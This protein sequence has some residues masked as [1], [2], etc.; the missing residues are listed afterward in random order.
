LQLGDVS[1][2]SKEAY[3]ASVRRWISE[4]VIIKSLADIVSHDNQTL[5]LFHD[6]D[7]TAGWSD[8]NWGL[9]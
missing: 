4:G 7:P 3:T 1:R 9:R 6:V 5:V 8:P 2:F